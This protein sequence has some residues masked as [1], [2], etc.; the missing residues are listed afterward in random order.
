ML[1]GVMQV[2]FALECAN[3]GDTSSMTCD[4]Q[5]KRAALGFSQT[6]R[7]NRCLYS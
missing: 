7:E 2:L 1:N 6:M 4:W 3:N 5:L